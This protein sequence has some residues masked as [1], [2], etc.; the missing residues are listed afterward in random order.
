MEFSM[1]SLALELL[2]F[3]PNPS[4]EQI[5]DFANVAGVDPD[6]LKDAVEKIQKGKQV[7]CESKPFF[8]GFTVVGGK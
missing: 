8:N 5:A 1:K 4:D 2:D 3:I 7:G 6:W